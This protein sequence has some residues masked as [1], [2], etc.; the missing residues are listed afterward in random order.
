MDKTTT[1]DKSTCK[2]DVQYTVICRLAMTILVLNLPLTEVM[3]GGTGET[4]T[5]YNTMS[6][7]EFHCITKHRSNTTSHFYEYY[8]FQCY[9][10]NPLS[11]PPTT[12]S[13]ETMTS[14]IAYRSLLVGVFLVFTSSSF[15][16]D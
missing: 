10:H 12:T 7:S 8:R 11:L 13:H 16:P 2:F 4:R 3:C 6:A 5:S 1:R 9:V 14:R 15:S